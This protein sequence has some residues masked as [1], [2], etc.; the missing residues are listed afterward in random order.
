M[1]INIPTTALA[2]CTH[3]ISIVVA[4][5]GIVVGEDRR[6]DWLIDCRRE[7]QHRARLCVVAAQTL[8]LER[9]ARRAA[10]RLRGDLIELLLTERDRHHHFA[11]VVQQSAQV[12]D[13]DRSAAALRQLKR[14]GCDR[15]RMD[16]HETDRRATVTRSLFQ[17][18]VGSRL[19][20]ETPDRDSARHRHR[21][22]IV[23]TLTGRDA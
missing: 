17:E 4:A 6:D 23:R 1:P 11:D 16:V 5:V 13:L 18:P 9:D 10:G 7:R 2:S 19:D 15:A 22:R 12:R 21:W 3:A 14:A 8:A 20:R